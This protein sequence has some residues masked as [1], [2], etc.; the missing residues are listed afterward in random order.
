MRFS[1]YCL[2]RGKVYLDITAKSDFLHN[3]RE[4]DDLAKE[5]GSLAIVNLGL[6]P[7]FTNL[8]AAEL[9][10]KFPFAEEV[11]TGLMLFLGEAHGRASIEWTI[12]NYTNDFI[13]SG[14]R[15]KSFVA[16]L[17]FTFPGFSTPRN[18]YRFN[19]PDQHA[20]KIT[21]EHCDFATYL[22]FDSNFVTKLLHAL[23]S[24]RVDGFLKIGWV[25][26]FFVRVLS[27]FSFG[28]MGFSG[29]CVAISKGKNVGRIAFLWRAHRP[30][31]GYHC[32]GGN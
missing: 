22:C 32:S 31:N 19:F 12:D 24:S 9:T 6:C 20:L 13:Y 21:Y 8:V 17:S 27:K 18:A 11:V 2:R 1:E 14:R 4:L 16:P 28:Q 30:C 10:S 3:L 26:S 15:Q 23:R 25:R 7:G 29:E 5:N